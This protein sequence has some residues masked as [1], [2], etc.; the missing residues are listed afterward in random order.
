MEG[1]MN[2]P[3]TLEIDPIIIITLLD[4]VDKKMYSLQCSTIEYGTD[5]TYERNALLDFKRKYQHLDTRR[6]VPSY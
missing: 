6:P 2:E 1:C 4:A 5:H 3:I